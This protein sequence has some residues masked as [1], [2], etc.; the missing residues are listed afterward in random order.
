MVLRNDGVS[1]ATIMFL[2]TPIFTFY[3]LNDIILNKKKVSRYLG[4]YKRV[5]RDQAYSIEQIQTALQNA[6]SR[7]R[8][9]ILILSSTGARIGSL[10]SLV[11]RN[12]TKMRDYGLYRMTFYEDT[13]NE[14]YTF[15]TRE[16]AA[17]GIDAYLQ[18]RQRCGEKISFNDNTGRWE[19]ENTPLIR[20][21]FDINDILQ[22][23]HPKPMTIH[24]LRIAFT[25][26]MIKCGIRQFEHPTAPNTSNRVRKSVPLFNGFRKRVISTFIE[27]ELNHEIREI[28][29]D[30]DTGLDKNYF[31]PT[32]NQVLQEYLKAEPLLTID[33]AVRLKQENQVLK[34]DRTNLESRLDHLEELYKSLL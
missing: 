31:R 12:I 6:D 20:Q 14:Y 23:R 18:F 29:V 9:I 21:Q 34:I 25:L 8:M 26:H 1:Y 16:C 4:E 24:A 7:M 2:I 30:H 19:P 5:V 10:S 17:T 32:E 22:A 33:P 3:H 11:L 15:T 28:I 13:K 27:A